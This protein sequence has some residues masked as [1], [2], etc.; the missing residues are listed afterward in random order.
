M[1]I[2]V[3]LDFPASGICTRTF[4]MSLCPRQMPAG[5]VCFCFSP[6][7]PTSC[8]KSFAGSE[9]LWVSSTGLWCKPVLLSVYPLTKHWQTQKEHTTLLQEEV[10]WPSAWL[11][12]LL[13]EII[14]RVRK[15]I[16][17]VHSSKCL[18]SKPRAG[19]QCRRGHSLLQLWHFYISLLSTGRKLFEKCQ[20]NGSGKSCSLLRDAFKQIN[21]GNLSDET[22]QELAVK[23]HWQ[24][25]RELFQPQ[26][27]SLCYQVKA[28][29]ESR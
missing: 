4:V 16:Y 7:W 29:Y 3:T 26:E 17:L 10:N 20:T 24:K 25:N 19:L 1:L 27:N 18:P 15:N 23:M 5:E 22:Q 14:K 2:R 6:C 28:N 9:S 21:W 12:P 13:C 8:Q 11:C